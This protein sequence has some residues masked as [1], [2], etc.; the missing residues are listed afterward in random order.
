MKKVIASMVAVAGLAAA[1]NAGQTRL[2]YEVSTD[3]VNWSSSASVSAGTRVEVRAR[4]TYIQEA[5]DPA[6]LGLAA[7]IFQPV[8]TGNFGAGVGQ[9]HFFGS[10]AAPEQVGNAGNNSNTA[11]S[12]NT[13]DANGTNIPF[14]TYGRA[15]P[16]A[17][18]NLTS[19]AGGTYP[20]G[21]YGSGTASG[22]MR[23][24]QGN[25]TNWIG[26]GSAGT[27][28]NNNSGRGGIPCATP[29]GAS[30]AG[31]GLSV[32]VFKFAIV[33]GDWNGA[34]RTIDIATPDNGFGLLVSGT[35]LVDDAGWWQADVT[36][37]G[38]MDKVVCR[39]VMGEHAQVRITP[40]PASLALLGLGGL[41]V[42]RRRR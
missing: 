30:P 41:V 36:G 25:I 38:L 10:G 37:D 19:T 12:G 28:L 4:A 1:A 21:F 42:A 31:P 8:G 22:M 7:L 15:F 40:T 5:G 2:S 17:N 32:V 14:G 24:A 26:T 16:F 23:I 39:A 33:A 9:D 13:F 18:N 34:D 27:S 11:S 29:P 20:R 3:G 35:S 6:V